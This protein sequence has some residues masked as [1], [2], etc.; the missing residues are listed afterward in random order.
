MV[1]AVAG[2][3]ALRGLSDELTAARIEHTL[4]VEEDSPYEGQ[5]MA[6]GLAPVRD[7]GPV[8]K[9]LS[10]LPLLKCLCGEVISHQE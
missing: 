3:G 1:L 10:Q 4:I 7:R 2:A 5:A 6:I 8:K 9:V